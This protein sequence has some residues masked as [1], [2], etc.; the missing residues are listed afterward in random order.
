[1][2]RWFR[3]FGAA[4]LIATS[5][6]GFINPNFT[7]IDLFRQSELVLVVS[8]DKI[9][10]DGKMTGTV[11]ETIKGEN[12][13]KE[14]VLDVLGAMD[15]PPQ[16]AILEVVRMGF[17]RGVFFTGKFQVT[18]EGAEGAGAGGGAPADNS[19]E[20]AFLHLAYPPSAQW[21]WVRLRKFEESWEVIK[22]DAFFM[23]T[24]AGGTEMAIAALRYFR[25][26]PEA[27]LPIESG[28]KWGEEISVGQVEGR[29]AAAAAVDL[30]GGGGPLTLFIASDAGDR[31]LRWREKAFEDLTS[32]REL[33]SQSR[34]FAFGD[35]TGD[36]RLDLASWDG[37]RIRIWA[38]E[39]NG[40]FS[41]VGDSGDDIADCLGLSA[42][43]AGAGRA[44][45]LISAKD[46]PI[47][48]TVA[49][50]G[51][52]AFAPLPPGEVSDL[53]EPAA[54]LAADFDGDGQTDILR[55]FA[56]GSRFYKGEA[57]GRFVAPVAA[58]PGKGRGRYAA[59][60][61]DF[62]HNGLPDIFTVAED[63]NRLWHND[64]GGRF[65]QMLSLC[66]EVPYIAK[67]EGIATAAVDFNND[68]RQDLFIAYSGLLPHLF[69]NRGFRSFGHARDVDLGV[70]SRLAVAAQGQQAGALADLN[71]DGVQDMA[72]VLRD[73]AVW[74]LW[75]QANERAL[76]VSAYLPAKAPSAGPVM[77]RAKRFE[78]ELGVLPVSPGG[79]AFFGARQP[80]PITVSWRFPGAAQQHKELVLE[81][82]PVRF[83]LAEP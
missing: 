75:G 7:L 79:T 76:A 33:A 60:I 28:A 14:I 29:V 4:V 54:A 1:M 12:A 6:R 66:G 34:Y 59:C 41:A 65:S 40:K 38:Q 25:D 18:G 39:G 71:G 20:I 61:G 13:P 51:S 24:F 49:A 83:N 69:F 80:G 17:K 50:D 77:V 11:V 58:G 36:G 78:R 15:G 64:G 42:L 53:G 43:D 30:D 57:L 27:E 37:R 3:W 63:G 55:L 8:F 9:A 82:D 32:A 31:L 26:D 46:A 67:P 22:P 81:A 16:R 10:E 19:E 47:I 45:L 74:V 68:G 62:D 52:W 35:F 70:Q 48:A 56:A 72:L 5:A 73:G 21:Q 23:G 2:T 44:S